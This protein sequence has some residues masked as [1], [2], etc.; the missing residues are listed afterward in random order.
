MTA[1]EIYSRGLIAGLKYTEMH[2]MHPGEILD[3]FV[4][5]RQYDMAINQL[6]EKK[7]GG[8]WD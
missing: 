1:R 5:R 4:W 3:Y 2:A 7:T 8:D 6:E